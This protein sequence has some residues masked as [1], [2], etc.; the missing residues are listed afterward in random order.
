M[1]Q[2][3]E[4]RMEVRRNVMARLTWTNSWCQSVK[5]N[6]IN[7]LVTNAGCRPTEVTQQVTSMAKSRRIGFFPHTTELA[8]CLMSKLPLCCLVSSHHR[9]D[10]W[11]LTCDHQWSQVKLWCSV[12]K[13]LFFTDVSPSKGGE[14]TSQQNTSN[15]QETL[16]NK[17]IFRHKHP[18]LFIYF[19]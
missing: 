12:Q 9:C 6:P 3:S 11:H 7:W 5:H 19:C 1:K 15:W 4:N 17:E 13:C 16:I 18:Y 14:N 8:V 10:L 2:I